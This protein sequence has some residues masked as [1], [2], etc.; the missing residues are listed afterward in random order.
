MSQH[1]I[2]AV[3]EENLLWRNGVVV[4]NGCLQQVRIR[5]GVEAQA[6]R[7]VTQFRLNRCQYPG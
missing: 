5:V 1:F 6:S 3:A 4:G 7:I 2:R